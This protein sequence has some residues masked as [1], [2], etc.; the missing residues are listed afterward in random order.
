MLLSVPYAAFGEEDKFMWSE[1][2][3][4]EI[5]LHNTGQFVVSGVAVPNLS[6]GHRVL[7]QV[8]WLFTLDQAKRRLGTTQGK[9]AALDMQRIGR[10][11]AEAYPPLRSTVQ[12]LLDAEPVVPK[13]KV[14]PPIPPRPTNFKPD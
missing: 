4:F 2:P 9:K 3:S 5:R 14:R 8:V 7:A 1:Y 10:A 11:C 6:E 13:T 12:A